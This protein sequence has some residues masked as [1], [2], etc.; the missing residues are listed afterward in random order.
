MCELTQRYRIHLFGDLQGIE[1]SLRRKNVRFFWMNCGARLFCRCQS[2]KW[3]V[4]SRHQL[5]FLINHLATNFCALIARRKYLTVFMAFVFLFSV[6]AKCNFIWSLN[7]RKPT[8]DRPTRKK[9][10][11][12]FVEIVSSK[13]HKWIIDWVQTGTGW[14]KKIGSN[15]KLIYYLRFDDILISLFPFPPGHPRA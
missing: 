11:N 15:K 9:Y 6:R 1:W 7:K 10:K 8:F 4:L 12:Q 14:K 13:N 3:N 2:R 5:F